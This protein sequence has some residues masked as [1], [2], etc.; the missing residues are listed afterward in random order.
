MTNNLLALWNVDL[1]LVDVA[2]V[3]RAA[4]AEAFAK[5]AGRPLIQL[6]QLAGRSESE[7]FFDALALNDADTGPAADDLLRPF[8]QELARSMRARRDDLT[9]HGQ[10]MPG[11][12]EALKAVQAQYGMQ[13]VLTGTSRSNALLKLAAF[14]LD[15]YLDLEI[16]GYGDESYPRGTMLHLVKQRAG[17]KYHQD[18]ETSAVYIADSPRDVDAAKIGAARCVAV[19]SGRS[20]A[21]ELREAGADAVLPDLTDTAALLAAIS[22]A[23][24]GAAGGRNEG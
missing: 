1:T 23:S 21:A 5:V 7:A 13:T 3:T 4:Y 12:A 15:G 24:A 10:V 22:P 6:P 16:G 8:S 2:R 20:T 14:D 11:A 18:F 17:Q 9:T 19:A